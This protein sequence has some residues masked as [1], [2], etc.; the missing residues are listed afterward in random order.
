MAQT[1]PD[2]DKGV[3]QANVVQANVVQVGQNVPLVEAQVIQAEVVQA[4]VQATIVGTPT[5]C[6]VVAAA[7]QLIFGDFPVQ[8]TCPSCQKVVTTN[9][10][11][12]I[13]QNTHIACVAW[14]ALCLCM[15]P[16]A[17]CCWAVYL[18]PAFKD[19]QHWCPQCNKCI[20]VKTAFA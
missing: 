12:K 3:V 8:C 10:V 5:T 9:V 15:C 6:G 11:A 1:Y 13:G 7:P 20:G 19:K 18:F 17:C 16:C 14:L 4:P 2:D